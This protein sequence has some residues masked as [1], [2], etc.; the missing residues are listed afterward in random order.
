MPGSTTAP[1]RSGACESAPARVAF[2]LWNGV[3]TRDK[4][5]SRLNGWPARSPTDASPAPS[6]VPAHGS[7]PMRFA[8]PSSQR[9]F[10]VYS[11]PVS[12]RTPQIHSLCGRR[13]FSTRGR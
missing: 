6:R 13:I 12:R 2:R 4:D 10:T 11:L 3:G 9:T 1:G 7:G 8:T 5:L